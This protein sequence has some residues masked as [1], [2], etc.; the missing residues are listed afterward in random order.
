[1]SLKVKFR[2][3][4]VK[5]LIMLFLKLTA[6]MK[7]PALEIAGFAIKVNLTCF[8]MNVFLNSL[9]FKAEYGRN[10]LVQSVQYQ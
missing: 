7:F 3:L 5:Y 6:L 9:W 8:P 4:I 2:S 1:M 10:V